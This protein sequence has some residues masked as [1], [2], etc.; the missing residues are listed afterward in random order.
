MSTSGRPVLSG[1]NSHANNES[2]L[3]VE[4]GQLALP[5]K[6]RGTGKLAPVALPP[7]GRF[8]F[9]KIYS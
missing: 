1:D 2:L 3:G 6:E 9:P 7:K 4:G 8:R 5:A